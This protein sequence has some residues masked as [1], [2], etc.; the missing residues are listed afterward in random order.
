MELRIGSTGRKEVE[1]E[2]TKG[3]LAGGC[4]FDFNKVCLHLL[5]RART[6]PALPAKTTNF[7]S[8]YRLQLVHAMLVALCHLEGL[9]RCSLQ[10][11]FFLFYAWQDLFMMAEQ[12]LNVMELC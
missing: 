5:R 6:G 12:L 4:C 11:S 9:T 8:P 1:D 3:N 7:T 10:C 2:P